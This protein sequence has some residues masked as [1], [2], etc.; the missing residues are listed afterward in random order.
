MGV[1]GGLTVPF[2]RFRNRCREIPHGPPAQQRVGFVG[3]E[4]EELC[5]VDRLRVT[6]VFPAT[7]P[8]FQDFIDEVLHGAVGFMP[9]SEIE[10]RSKLCACIPGLTYL[11]H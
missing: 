5:L 1:P 8:L 11:P 6:S 4:L 3:A 9:G 2:D 10:S 7:G